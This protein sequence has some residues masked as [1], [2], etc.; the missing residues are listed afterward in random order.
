M[1][2]RVLLILVFRTDH[3]L[4]GRNHSSKISVDSTPTTSGWSGFWEHKVA[5]NRDTY[6]MAQNRDNEAK[7]VLSGG[8]SSLPRLCRT[9]LQHGDFHSGM[10]LCPRPS[11]S[12]QQALPCILFKLLPPYHIRFSFCP[13]RGPY[14]AIFSFGSLFSVYTGC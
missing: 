7:I 1:T 11:F 3:L 2:I 5:Q 10:V 14:R 9:A 8:A 12:R 13:C 6:E 4:D